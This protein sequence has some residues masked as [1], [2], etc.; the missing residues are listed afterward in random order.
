MPFTDLLE[1]I[2]I[3]RV[4]AVEDCAP[5]HLD[6]KAAEPAMRIMQ[7]PRA[8]MV[9]RG[10]RDLQRT[11][12]VTFPIVQ[13][14]DAP[15]A[16]VMDQISHL[17]GHHDRLVLRHFPQRFAI[18]MIEV[19]VRHEDEIDIRQI[20]QGEPG[21]LHALDHL[22]P[23]RPVRVDEHTEPLRLEQEGRVADPRHRNLALAHFGKR[24]TFIAAVAPGEDR[25][26]EHL[27]QKVAPLPAVLRL[28]A[29]LLGRSGARQRGMPFAFC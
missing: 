27:G 25:G 18:E 26:N 7:H 22:Q 16:E 2:E 19:G 13:L 3:C 29:H 10:E 12:F 15:E 17:K 11:V 14:V 9:A 8:P 4:A 6:D 5:R 24:R 1:T 21:V 20:V 23:L 28:E